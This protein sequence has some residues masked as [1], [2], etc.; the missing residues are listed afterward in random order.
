VKREFFWLAWENYLRGLILYK[1][2][3]LPYPPMTRYIIA[4][5][6][7]IIIKKSLEVAY[8]HNT[9][10]YTLWCRVMYLLWLRQT[11]HVDKK[12]STIGPMMTGVHATKDRKPSIISDTNVCYCRRRW[13]TTI[14]IIIPNN[15]YNIRKWVLWKKNESS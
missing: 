7:I 2:Y 14:T 12:K 9:V 5:I 1:A 6:M 3:L 13:S 11:F 10:E 4:T 15:N 8:I